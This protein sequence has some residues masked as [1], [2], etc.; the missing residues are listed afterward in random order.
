MID[1]GM[2]LGIL[3]KLLPILYGVAL[4][5]YLV[6][7]VSNDPRVRRLARPTLLLA[8]IANVVYVLGYTTHFEHIPMVN[9][10]QVLG[11]VGFAVAVIYV[12]VEAKT[13]T[14][15][16]GSFVL[17]LV[18]IFQVL[19]SMFPKLDHEVPEILQSKLFSLH[20]TAAVLGYSA[21]ALAAV[22]GVLYLLQYRAIRKQ[23]FGL[24]F[25]RLP[26]LDILDRMN[27]YASAA[28]FALLTLAIVAGGVWS[29][30]I[31][32]SVKIDPKVMV[33]ILTWVVYGVSLGGRHL[34]SWQGPRM[35]SS[36]VVGFLVILF[37]MFAVNFWLTKFH[38]FV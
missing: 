7:F 35:A 4:V 31:Y 2:F 22:Y 26:S 30:Q 36:S 15:H 23:K 24:V 1:T 12:W 17:A 29:S 37:S 20:V 8:V 38:V 25:R 14:L 18:L 5:N 11:G 9:V 19:N 16:T 13:D 27:Y 10:F 28:G 6:F 33:A 34:V 21:F 3:L 32:G